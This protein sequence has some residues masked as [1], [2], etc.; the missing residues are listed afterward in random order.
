[1]TIHKPPR[2][3]E[4]QH[5]T[6]ECPRRARAVDEIMAR[7]EARERGETAPEATKPQ[8]APQPRRVPPLPLLEDGFT[9]GDAIGSA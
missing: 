8:G 7:I 5:A 9:C 6:R 1:M 2:R 3:P 4:I